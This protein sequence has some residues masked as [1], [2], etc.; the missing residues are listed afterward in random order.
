MLCVVSTGRPLGTTCRRNVPSTKGKEEEKTRGRR[1]ESQVEESEPCV[2]VACLY[3]YS[4]VCG[5]GWWWEKTF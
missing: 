3:N 2:L 4:G 1:R 5:G